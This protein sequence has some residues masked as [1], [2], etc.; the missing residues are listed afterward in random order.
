[1]IMEEE[2]IKPGDPEL[3]KFYEDMIRIEREKAE[4]ARKT[5]LNQMIRKI[6]KKTK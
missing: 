3:D 1:M 4:R 6:T 2:T 5:K